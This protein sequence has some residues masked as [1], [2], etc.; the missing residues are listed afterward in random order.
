MTREGGSEKVDLEGQD[1][2]QREGVD[3]G[4]SGLYCGTSCVG[5]M[6]ASGEGHLGRRIWEQEWLQTVTDTVNAV[7]IV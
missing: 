7:V 3:R 2:A 4:G 6:S 1:S 5:L